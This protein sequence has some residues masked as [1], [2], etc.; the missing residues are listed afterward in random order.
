MITGPSIGP[1]MVLNI[2][3]RWPLLIVVCA[4]GGTGTI[5]YK[6]VPEAQAAVQTV[7]GSE[8]PAAPP[9]VE[10]PPV[11][12]TSPIAGTPSS[13]TRLLTTANEPKKP[14]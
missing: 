5:V 9:A 11:K 2:L 13:T 8:P 14:R 1:A 4:A 7:I 3:M 6:N 12:V 10:P